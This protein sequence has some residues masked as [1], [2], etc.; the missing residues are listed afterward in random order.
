[1]LSRP[2]EQAPGHFGLAVSDYTHS[3]AP[4]RRYP[5]LLTQRLVTEQEDNAA[6]AERQVLKSAAVLLLAP[7]IGQR[8]DAIVTG[9][10]AQ[11]TSVR[12]VHPVAEGR[13]VQGYEGLDVGDRAR[14]ELIAVDAVLGHIG[15]RRSAG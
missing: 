2:G 14:V 10:S 15:F 6:R 5:D 9:V 7:R 1:M 12:I 11:A 4:N 8:F 13:V 3:T